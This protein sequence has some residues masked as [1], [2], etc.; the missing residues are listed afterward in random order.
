LPHISRMLQP[1]QGSIVFSDARFQKEIS[2]SREK[3]VELKH[4]H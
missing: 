2:N 3:F 4:F 1:I